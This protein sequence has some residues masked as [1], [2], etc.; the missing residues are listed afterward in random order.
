MVNFKISIDRADEIASTLVKL[1]INKQN[2]QVAAV[3]DTQPAYYEFML[4][5]EAGNRRTEIFLTR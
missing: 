1:G 4:S 2:I 5:G 3:S